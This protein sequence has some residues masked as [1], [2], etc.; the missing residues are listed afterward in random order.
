MNIHIYIYKSIWTCGLTR[1]I[2]GLLQP[3]K[4]LYHN[5]P[6][7][8]QIY[9]YIYIHREFPEDHNLQTYVLSKAWSCCFQSHAIIQYSPFKRQFP[10]GSFPRLPVPSGGGGGGPTFRCHLVA[11]VLEWDQRVPRDSTGFT[12]LTRRRVSTL[13]WMS[14]MA[15]S[16]W[17]NL[18]GINHKSLEVFL[19]ALWCKHSLSIPKTMPP[20]KNFSFNEG[21]S[22]ECYAIVLYIFSL[23]WILADTFCSLFDEMAPKNG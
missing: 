16:G 19:K 5:M 7:Y 17:W 21:I 3:P 11:A 13:K 23:R 22:R 6:I 14:S 10:V 9:K 15:V 4:H 18:G 20:K 2:G 1:L 8:M 12:H